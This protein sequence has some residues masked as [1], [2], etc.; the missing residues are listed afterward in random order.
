LVVPGGGFEFV[1]TG[2]GIKQTPWQLSFGGQKKKKIEITK[3][4]IV[5]NGKMEGEQ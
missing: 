2:L 5:I 4:A 1:G 3:S